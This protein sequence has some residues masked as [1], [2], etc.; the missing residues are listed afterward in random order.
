MQSLAGPTITNPTTNPQSWTGPVSG[1]CTLNI[2]GPQSYSSITINAGT[3]APFIV[4]FSGNIQVGNGGT[5]GAAI[6][7]T[8]NAVVNFSSCAL[9]KAL[10]GTA[11]PTFVA[12]RAWTELY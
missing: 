7:V 10:A 5:S 11:T 4:N 8:G 12:R 2:S 6:I 3:C 9:T 1:S